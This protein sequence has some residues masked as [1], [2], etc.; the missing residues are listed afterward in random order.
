MCRIEQPNYVHSGVKGRSHIT[1]ATQHIGF[2]NLLTSDIQSFYPSTT[3]KMV[4]NFFLKRM[5]CSPDVAELI[6]SLCTCKGHIPTGSRISMPL[7]YWANEPMFNLLFKYSVPKGIKFTIFVDDIVFSGNEINKA[8]IHNIKKIVSDHGHTAHPRKTKFYEAGKTKVI[9]GVA[10][11]SDGLLVANKHRKKIY[12]DVSQWKITE[13]AGIQFEQLNN[14][15]L[16]RMNSQSLVD[17][18]F[19]DKART[20][21]LSIA[22]V[23]QA[24]LQT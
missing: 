21:K 24:K 2:H 17:Y 18:R 9:T 13:E 14:R 3:K 15:I 12:Q 22:K 11:G 16:G 7:A 8:F 10:V 19:K 1:N 6:S 5:E 20:L 4:F 23:V